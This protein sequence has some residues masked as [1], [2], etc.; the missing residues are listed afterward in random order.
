MDK[1]TIDEFL[2]EYEAVTTAE[3]ILAAQALKRLKDEPS[4][5]PEFE[6]VSDFGKGVVLRNNLI[7]K[8]ENNELD[9]LTKIQMLDSLA[10][11]EAYMRVKTTVS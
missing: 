2:D 1:M 3:E 4:L 7:P 9:C 5:I 8:F 11:F 6:A 10:K